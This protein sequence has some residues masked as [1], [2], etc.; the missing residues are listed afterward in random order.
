MTLIG[1]GFNPHVPQHEYQELSTLY[2]KN[3]LL[4]VQTHAYLPKRVEDF[5]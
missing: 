4:W 2:A 5:L 3:V 1:V